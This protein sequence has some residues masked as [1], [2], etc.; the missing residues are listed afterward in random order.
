MIEDTLAHMALSEDIHID[1]VLRRALLGWSVE[2]QG[3]VHLLV[4]DGADSWVRA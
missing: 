1:A 2:V 3:Q 4:F